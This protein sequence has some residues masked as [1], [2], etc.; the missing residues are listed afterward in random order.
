MLENAESIGRVLALIVLSICK[1]DTVSSTLQE[2]AIQTI[3]NLVL[4][5]VT[6]SSQPKGG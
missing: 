5:K 1:C 4:S 3:Y 2:L 6:L